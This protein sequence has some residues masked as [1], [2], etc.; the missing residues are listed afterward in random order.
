MEMGKLYYVVRWGV[1]YYASEGGDGGGRQL[2]VFADEG[3][4]REEAHRRGTDTIE[5]KDRA[6]V[7][8]LARELARTQGYERLCIVGERDDRQVVDVEDLGD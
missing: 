1:D 2:L 6:A 8:E 4:A 3:A 7:I 5:P